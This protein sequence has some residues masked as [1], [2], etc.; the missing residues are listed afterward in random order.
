MRRRDHGRADRAMRTNRQRA[1]R[2]GD[3]KLHPHLQQGPVHQPRTDARLSCGHDL[4]DPVPTER[5]RILRLDRDLWLA[6]GGTE[7]CRT[8]K[9]GRLTRDPLESQLGELRIEAQNCV[10]S[11][12]PAA[13]VYSDICNESGYG[14]G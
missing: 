2:V 8:Q 13:F 10:A 4:H 1:V 6:D 5:P 14:G 7:P 12:Y 11:R 9:F 3:P